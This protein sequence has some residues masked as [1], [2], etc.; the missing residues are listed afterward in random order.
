MFVARFEQKKPCQMAWQQDLMKP[1][2]QVDIDG[3]HRLKILKLETTPMSVSRLNMLKKNCFVLKHALPM[4]PSTMTRSVTPS[5]FDTKKAPAKVASL[6]ASGKIRQAS[7]TVCFSNS[8]LYGRFLSSSCP[9]VLKW[10]IARLSCFRIGNVG[11]LFRF[12]PFQKSALRMIIWKSKAHS[13][14]DACVCVPDQ[15]A[16]VQPCHQRGIDVI[17]ALD[18]WRLRFIVCRLA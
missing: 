9:L 16:Q 17:D 1:M 5:D 12:I 15:F 3:G 6:R 8:W 2:T 18:N 4:R 13:S 11:N 10:S 14:C 7:C